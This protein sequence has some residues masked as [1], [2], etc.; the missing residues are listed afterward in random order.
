MQCVDLPGPLRAIEDP[1]E[2][3]AAIRAWAFKMVTGRGPSK[4]DVLSGTLDRLLKAG[5]YF[6]PKTGSEVRFAVPDNR[7]RTL[8]AGA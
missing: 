4:N 2:R 7:K 3:N 1:A 6:D 5:V 8:V